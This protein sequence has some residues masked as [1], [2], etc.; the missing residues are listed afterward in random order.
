MVVGLEVEDNL[1]IPPSSGSATWR[2]L[3]LGSARILSLQAGK[4]SGFSFGCTTNLTEGTLH[5]PSRDCRVASAETYRVQNERYC[6][7]K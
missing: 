4:E 6:S 7:S 2:P 1:N 5:E 3:I